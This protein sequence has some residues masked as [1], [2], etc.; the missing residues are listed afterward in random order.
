MQIR[1][2]E[3][4]DVRLLRATENPLQLI[5]QATAITMKKDFETG[6]GISDNICKN[7]Y[8]MNH[9]SL[10]EHIGYTFLIVGASR[11]FLAQITR[12]RI[13]SFTSGSQH[14]QDYGNYGFTVNTKDITEGSI[15]DMEMM[16]K[17]CM[18]LYQRLL[19]EGL[20]KEEA[21]QILPG[22]M[23]NNLLWTV[24]AR[25][26]ANFLNLRLCHRN[27]KEMQIVAWKILSLSI[28][29][30]PELFNFVGP[31]CFIKECT[32]KGMSCGTLWTKPL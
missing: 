18:D 10:L 15:F 1:D 2:Y 25:S 4:I 26:L 31:D 30:F 32:Q 5:K 17:A 21:R 28:G 23:E 6:E 14:Y 8:H 22:G 12:H 11:S 7:L 20:P 24:N 13:S 27:V 19:S 3:E 9:Q 29:H 16:A